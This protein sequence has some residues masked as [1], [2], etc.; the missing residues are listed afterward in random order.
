LRPDSSADESAQADFPAAGS[1]ADEPARD[2]VAVT[3]PE[4]EAEP[5]AEPAAEPA[6]ASEPAAE[7]A[8]ARSADEES[9]D[10]DPDT[11][12]RPLLSWIGRS[13]P[14]LPGRDPLW[15]RLLVV[16][17]TVLV[18]LAGASIAAERLVANRI[19]DSVHKG[20]LLEPGARAQ[21]VEPNSSLRGPLNYLLIGSDYRDWAPGNG[22]R[23]DTIIILHIPASL[24]RAYLISI[25]RDLRVDIP[26]YPPTG[27]KG[28]HGVKING[29]FQFGGG[30]EGGAQLVSATLTK[31][32]GIHFDG[33]AI[34]DFDG[35]KKAVELLGGVDMC[36]DERTESHH[37]GF[38][39]DGHF[40]APWKGE[41]DNEYRVREST[42]YVYEVGCRHLVPWQA[43]DYVR[44]RKSIPDG[45]WGRA[46]HQQQFLRAM[47]DEAIRQGIATDPRK[48]G[49]MID[50]IGS[51]L[52]VDTNGVP[53]ADLVY[54]LRSIRPSSL[55]GIRL[56]GVDQYINGYA[57]VIQTEQAETLYAAV[58]DD[59]LE[60]WTAT[61]S[62]YVEPF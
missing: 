27:Y 47:L 43:L 12:R 22:A 11:R 51:S 49:A 30:G 57:Y 53:L 32:T 24:D 52:T 19:E 5:E 1:L 39:K 48:A 61:N 55:V 31:L 60:E 38:D 44:Q 46:R 26:P 10:P 45:D 16:F 23:S 42:P 9:W 3:D 25:Q 17:G 18:L 41:N 34:I 58:R 37:V 29:A 15:A 35:F 36:I 20:N 7:P 59:T 33:G 54:G 4:P 14:R 21:P 8:V 28:E 50:A 13:R 6:A 56:P 2:A 62:S 40:L